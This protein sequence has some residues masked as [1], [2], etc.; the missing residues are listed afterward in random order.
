[1]LDL[2]EKVKTLKKQV[3]ETEKT[4]LI[5]MHNNGKFSAF[6]KDSRFGMLYK[7]LGFKE[8]VDHLDTA[9]H[10]QAVSNEFIQKIN[11]EYLFVLDRSVVVNKK[12]TNKK[13]IE[14]QL[15]KKTRAYENGNV[16][17]LDPE[18]WYISGDGVASFKKK[19][20]G[21]SDNL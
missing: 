4:A 18:A 7:L 13:A 2:E 6:G 12:A 8:A 5:V 17:Y 20:K 19:I 1:M 15:V 21:I 9:R 14:N 10:G 11:P 16:I 3:T